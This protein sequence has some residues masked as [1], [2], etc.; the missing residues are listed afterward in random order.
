MKKSLT[1]FLLLIVT[2][3]SAF[4]ADYP[5]KEP[6]KA[7]LVLDSKTI[8]LQ[9]NVLKQSWKVTNNKLV[10]EK[11]SDIPGNTSI[12][13]SVSELFSVMIAG[14]LQSSSEFKVM[15]APKEYELIPTKESG[16]AFPALYW[17]SS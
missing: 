12:D 8:V 17:Q 15:T 2:G 7:V 14:K 3:F 13:L 6:G 11:I 10:S 4:A 9:N 1:I 16:Q 5:G